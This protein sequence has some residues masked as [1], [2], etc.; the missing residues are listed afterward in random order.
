MDP[1]D[2]IDCRGEKIEDD[3][4]AFLR[5]RAEP[6]ADVEIHNIR[7]SD[8]IAQSPPGCCP[9]PGRWKIV[10]TD[11]VKGNRPQRVSSVFGP[12]KVPMKISLCTETSLTF[13]AELHATGKIK[14][15]LGLIEAEVGVKLST[16]VTIKKGECISWT[17]PAGR[18]Q[19]LAAV[20]IYTRREIRREDYD[21]HCKR[22]D[23]SVTVLSPRGSSKAVIG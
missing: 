6:Y 23:D 1:V 13:G 11:V 8:D 14:P 2:V 16:S 18:V 20:A 10:N 15:V 3:Q 5:S 22:A 7:V 19:Y 17:V 21:A 9:Y 12:S 4:I